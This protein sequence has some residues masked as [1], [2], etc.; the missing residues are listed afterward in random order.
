MITTQDFND[1]LQTAYVVSGVLTKKEYKFLPEVIKAD[2]EILALASGF[3]TYVTSTGNATAANSSIGS[4]VFVVTSQRLLFVDKGMVFGVKV[5]EIP[6]HHINGVNYNIGPLFGNIIVTNGFKK[7]AF[8]G[9]AKGGVIGVVERINKLAET[10]NTNDAP[11][12]IATNEQ[13]VT[14]AYI[15]E[16]KELKNLLDVGVLTNAEFEAKKAS[17]LAR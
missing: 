7:V 1:K 2:E 16:L 12:V 10:T 13:S 14:P 11:K 8:E 9:I 5:T 3:M 4:G 17:I 6:K 15:V